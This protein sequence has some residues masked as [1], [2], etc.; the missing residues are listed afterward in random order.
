MTTVADRLRPRL[1]DRYAVEH[2]VGR[3]GAACTFALAGRSDRAFGGLDMAVQSGFGH[4]EW[5]E[6]DSALDSLRSDPRFDSL[7]KKL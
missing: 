6:T 2:Q 5:L 7:L 1:A 4:K 3:G